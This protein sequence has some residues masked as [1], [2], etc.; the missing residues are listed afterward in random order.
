MFN[1]A[2][3][4][5]RVRFDVSVVK[6][7]YELDN[8]VNFKRN[9]D[10]ITINIGFIK[11]D[12]KYLVDLKLPCHLFTADER[13][14]INNSLDSKIV[15][16]SNIHTRI[17]GFSDCITD[18]KYDYYN[19]KMEIIVYADK[20]YKEILSIKCPQFWS[21]PIKVV[22]SASVLGKGKG[23]PLLR[24]GV[25]CTG[26]IVDEELKYRVDNDLSPVEEEFQGSEEDED[27]IPSPED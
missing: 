1:C 25:H 6:T 8:S 21:K 27:L 26:C 13:E 16:T 7:D 20:Y 19:M 11:A 14:M 15:T 3:T 12:H 22:I 24:N 23:T 2:F 18:D 17:V 4:G 5:Q 10:S 9:E